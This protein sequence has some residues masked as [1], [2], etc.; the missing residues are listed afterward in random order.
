M[1]TPNSLD[2][3]PR[4]ALVRCERYDEQMVHD[5]VGKGLSLLGGAARFVS[6]GESILLKPNLRVASHPDRAV[7]THPTVFRAVA[8]HLRAAGAQ[9]SYGDSPGPRGRLGGL[10]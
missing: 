4:V 5:A 3:P 9:L 10:G 6:V 2:R 8:Q 7:T 1:Q